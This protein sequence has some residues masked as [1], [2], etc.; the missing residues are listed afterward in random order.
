MECAE[1]ARAAVGIVGV[2][3]AADGVANMPTQ[4]W[5]WHPEHPLWDEPNQERVAVAAAFAGGAAEC[6]AARIE[7]DETGECA[8]DVN[9][10][11][12]VGNDVAG[13]DGAILSAKV[14]YLEEIAGGV[15]LVDVGV[16]RP[17]LRGE[18]GDISFF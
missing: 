8:A 7:I 4:A 14:L 18:R 10:I 5:A 13:K 3:S 6:A 2:A 11:G 15:E 9:T 16:A 12:A 17:K 1:V